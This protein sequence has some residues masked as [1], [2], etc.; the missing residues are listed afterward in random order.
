VNLFSGWIRKAVKYKKHLQSVRRRRGEGSKYL[1]AN[2]SV[3]IMPTVHCMSDKRYEKGDE[4][5]G[6]RNVLY[7]ATGRRGG[8]VTMHLFGLGAVQQNPQP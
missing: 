5:T 4:K 2:P 3:S 7:T 8:A 1:G 6:A